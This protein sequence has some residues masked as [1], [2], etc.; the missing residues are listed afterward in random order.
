ML[1]GPPIM[2]EDGM[3]RCLP[4]RTSKPALVVALRIRGLSKDRFD[5]DRS[6]YVQLGQPERI[7][8][9]ITRNARHS[10][11]NDFGLSE[12]QLRVARRIAGGDGL[13]EAAEALGISVNTDRTHL[14]RLYEK[15]G[16]NTRTAL[17]RL[18]L[19]VG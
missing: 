3:A 10:S 15:T 9:P 16:F 4:R 18:L 7:F 6:I 12:G 11:A 5:V 14:A 13:K 2:S 8:E 1:G 19:S 17:V